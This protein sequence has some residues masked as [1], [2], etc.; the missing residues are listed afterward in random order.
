MAKIHSDVTELPASCKS[1]AEHVAAELAKEDTFANL[2]EAWIGRL[3]EWEAEIG[4]EIGES[5]ALVACR[6]S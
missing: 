2:N 3:T 1:A 4:R 5:V 6:L